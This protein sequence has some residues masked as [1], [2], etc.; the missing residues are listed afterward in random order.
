MEVRKRNLIMEIPTG[1][2]T[3]RRSVSIFVL[4]Q[5]TKGTIG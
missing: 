1:L 5:V 4:H 2:R 3:E